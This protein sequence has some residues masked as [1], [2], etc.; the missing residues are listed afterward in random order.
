MKGGNARRPEGESA[1][2]KGRVGEWLEFVFFGK[3]IQIRKEM[4]LYSKQ[5]AM[6]DFKEKMKKRTLGVAVKALLICDQ[7]PSS[8][9][10]TTIINQLTRSVTSVGANYREACRAKS[11]ADF[12]SKLQTVESECDESLY[13]VEL[14][15]ARNES[16]TISLRAV[17]VELNEII[18][19]LVTAIKTAKGNG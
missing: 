3:K 10:N 5:N 18:S 6:N 2:M 4:H 8:P 1:R 13:W 19:V 15:E 9:A 7:L 12:V 14:L 11:R 16:P 17:K